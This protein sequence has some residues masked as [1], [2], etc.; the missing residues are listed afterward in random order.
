MNESQPNSSQE[1]AACVNLR[2]K[3]PPNGVKKQD[4]SQNKSLNSIKLNQ[5][6]SISELLERMRLNKNN[7]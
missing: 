2:V 3:L 6:A 5:T 4:L 7:F 1:V